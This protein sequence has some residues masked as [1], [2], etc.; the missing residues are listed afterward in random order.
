MSNVCSMIKTCSKVLCSYFLGSLVG[1][2][3]SFFYSKTEIIILTIFSLAFFSENVIA[4]S[5]EF[6]VNVYLKFMV[7]GI[8]P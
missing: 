5:K 2:F 4:V 8:D 7:L 3:L 1:F 6:D